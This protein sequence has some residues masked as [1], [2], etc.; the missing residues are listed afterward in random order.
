MTD[1][2]LGHPSVSAPPMWQGGHCTL[3]VLGDD[4]VV[5]RRLQDYCPSIAFSSSIHHCSGNPFPE[6]WLW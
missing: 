5:A 1:A 4:Q 3:P 6:V 2:T